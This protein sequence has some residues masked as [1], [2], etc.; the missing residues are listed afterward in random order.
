MTRNISCRL[1]GGS[2]LFVFEKQI[3]SKYQIGYYLC[4]N[5]GALQTEVPY[6]LEEAY[7]PL[8]EK[9]DTGQLFRSLNNAAVMNIFI[10]QLE[11]SRGPIIDYGCGSGLLTRL[12][13]DLGLDAWGFDTYSMPRLAIGFH[14]STLQGAKGINLCE[15]AEHFDNPSKYFDEIFSTGTEMLLMQTGIFESL[16][17]D[18]GYLSVEHGQHIFFYSPK[19]IKYLAKRYSMAATFIHGF[20]LFFKPIHIEKL[21]LPNS[22]IMRLELQEG[23]NNSMQNLMSQILAN[24]YKHADNDYALLKNLRLDQA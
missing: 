18:W 3:L 17:P 6:W 22:S 16:D 13:R 10:T 15:V 23:L 11:L 2:S 14:A 1:C 4:N 7:D 24:G 19:T 9:F 21:F 20:I 5:C 12:L 8:N